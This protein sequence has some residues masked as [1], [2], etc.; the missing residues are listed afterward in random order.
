[1]LIPLQGGCILGAHC[2][3][4]GCGNLSHS[5]QKETNWLDSQSVQ[6]L[7]QDRIDLLP[8][9]VGEGFCMHSQI[10]AC[11]TCQFC[12]HCVTPAILTPNRCKV[13]RCHRCVCDLLLCVCDL[14]AQAIKYSGNF[15]SVHKT[16]RCV[17]LM[18]GLDKED[19]NQDSL[20]IAHTCNCAGEPCRRHLHRHSTKLIR[21]RCYFPMVCH[22]NV[23]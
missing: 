3:W 9:T 21:F 6:D 18:F 14:C 8:P 2:V 10:F 13:P 1:M 12:L 16:V 20:Q 17:K 4:P 15:T 11:G 19:L 22:K 5:H 7:Q 23:M